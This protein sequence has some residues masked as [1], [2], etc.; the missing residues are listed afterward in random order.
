MT[1]KVLSAIVAFAMVFQGVAAFATAGTST[2]EDYN[3]AM[4][5]TLTTGNSTTDPLTIGVSAEVA[6]NGPVYKIQVSWGA[7][8]FKFDAPSTA[9]DPV[10]HTYNSTAGA[11]TTKSAWTAAGVDGTNNKITITND[12]AYA[13]GA[14]FDYIPNTPNPLNANPNGTDNVVPLFRLNNGDFTTLRTKLTGTSLNG[15]NSADAPISFGGLTHS[16][17]AYNDETGVDPRMAS[18]KTILFLPTADQYPPAVGSV[19]YQKGARTCDVFF[20]FA[21]TPDNVAFSSKQVGNITIDFYP[22]SI[23][24][25]NNTNNYTDGVNI[26]HFQTTD[27][28][29]L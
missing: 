17:N 22:C 27:G 14:T 4:T 1:K 15:T 21:G 26:P 5:N 7:M 25:L 29:W 16:G 11:G 24:L 20:G 23:G 12:S 9:W 28:K 19:G 18:A 6:A 3:Q 2:L 13:I 8:N 10:S